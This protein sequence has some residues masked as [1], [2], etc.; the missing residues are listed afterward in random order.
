MARVQFPAATEYFKGFSLANHVLPTRPVPAWQK[1]LNLLSITPQTNLWTSRRKAEIQPW[2]NNGW[3]KDSHKKYFGGNTLS[4][5]LT[6]WVIE[7]LMSSMISIINWSIMNNNNWLPAE[8]QSLYTRYS[9]SGIRAQIY[10]TL[11]S[12]RCDHTTS[13]TRC[14]PLRG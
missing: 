4:F 9:C 8:Y 2:A 11:Y 12:M 10:G 14:E 5:L 1:W 6:F 7:S 3:K 13:Q